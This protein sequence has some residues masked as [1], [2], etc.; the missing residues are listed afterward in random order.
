MKRLDELTI[1]DCLY[2]V[3]LEKITEVKIDSITSNKDGYISIKPKG[4]NFY[5]G[6]AESNMVKPDDT[7]LCIPYYSC[8]EAAKEAQKEMIKNHL[9]KLRVNIELSLKEYNDF[10]IKNNL[11]S[12][13]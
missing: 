8:Y 9:I 2:V 4:R 1:K 3:G 6:K 5:E 12:I 11:G 10:I 13:N 7:P